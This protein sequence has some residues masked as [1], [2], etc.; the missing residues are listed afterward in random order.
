VIHISK[1]GFFG[2][3]VFESTS[4]HGRFI[5]QLKDLSAYHMQRPYAFQMKN[6]SCLTVERACSY[7]SPLIYR[8]VPSRLSLKLG[9]A[10]RSRQNPI[11]IQEAKVSCFEPGHT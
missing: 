1:A 4:L 5:H 3:V 6:L 2:G 10:L 11:L 7:N 8:P 9:K